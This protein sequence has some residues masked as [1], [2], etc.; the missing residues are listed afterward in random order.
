MGDEVL[1]FIGLIRDSAPRVQT[2]IFSAGGCYQFYLILKRVFPEA[3][4]YSDLNHV[5]SR[6]GERYYDINGDVT[7]EVK[8]G[9]FTEMTGEPYWG[10]R[11]FLT[12]EFHLMP[13]PERV[14][15]CKADV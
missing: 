7:E 11:Y 9:R 10:K 13:M 15:T 2:Q 12:D 8:R 3:V 14:E 1:E 5:V 4:P 6:I